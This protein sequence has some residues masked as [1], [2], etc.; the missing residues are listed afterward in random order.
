MNNIQKLIDGITDEL[1]QA[2]MQAK[3]TDNEINKAWANGYYSACKKHR[4]KLMLLLEDESKQPQPPISQ[5]PMLGEVPP[6]VND[7]TEENSQAV[8]GATPVVGSSA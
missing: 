3:A 1:L 7:G 2:E 5:T 8:E 6:V 4:R